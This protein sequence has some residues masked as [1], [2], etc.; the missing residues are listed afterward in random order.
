MSPSVDIDD[1][2]EAARARVAAEAAAAANAE[3]DA[4]DRWRAGADG[5][6]SLAARVCATLERLRASVPPTIETTVVE[7]VDLVSIG[8]FRGNRLVKTHTAVEVPTWPADVVIFAESLGVCD[9]PFYLRRPYSHPA[10]RQPTDPRP[11]VAQLSFVLVE[12]GELRI[13]QAWWVPKEV[14]Q[15]DL[16]LRYE[17]EESRA[18]QSFPSCAHWVEDVRDAGPETSADWMLNLRSEW[19]DALIASAADRIVSATS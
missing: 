2:I 13:S 15:P 17:Y 14:R 11:T 8:R 16:T 1:A 7:S 10:D 6:A 4:A 18:T 9:E 5:R 19:V 12:H 3:R